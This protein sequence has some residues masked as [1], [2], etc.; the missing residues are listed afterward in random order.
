[1]AKRSPK[2][3]TSRQLTETARLLQ[4][5]HELRTQCPWDKKQTH[6]TLRRYLL[7]EAYEA[8]DAIET[9][10]SDLLTEELGDVLLQVALHAEI[11]SETKKFDFEK[12]AK[13]ISAKM[14]RRHPHI[15]AKEKA[16]LDEKTHLKNWTKLKE[17]E[18][19]KSSLLEGIPKAMPALA[20]A[21]RYGEIA[22]SVGFDWHC[23]QD[24]LEKV[25]EEFQEL[26]DELNAKNPKMERI[27]M[28]LGDVLFTLTQFA[29]HLKLDAE[30]AL[31]RS[32]AKFESRFTAL[33]KKKKKEGKRL[34]DC[35]PDELEKDWGLVKSRKGAHL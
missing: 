30:G 7:E 35:P 25:D 3:P 13:A 16:A 9:G 14:I 10:K 11:A 1:M 20:L 29:R 32:T 23:E 33:E 24:V 5:V 8:A 28:E 22:A 19:P 31:K 4:V 6:K 21:Q 27:E 26:L 34:S 18:K 17:K 12:I 15:Y 2:K